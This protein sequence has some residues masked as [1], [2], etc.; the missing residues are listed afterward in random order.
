MTHFKTLLVALVLGAAATAQ[1]QL[2]NIDASHGF[3][4]DGGGSDP[5]PL[6][7]QHI[8]PIGAPVTLALGAGTYRVRNAAGQAGALFDAWS[9]NLGTSSWAWAFVTYDAGSQNTLFYAQAGSGSSRAQVAA[10]PQVQA[11]ETTFTLAQATTVGFTLRDY[12]VPDNG[13]GISLRVSAVP[14]P[15]MALLWLLGAAPL[16]RIA[17]RRGQRA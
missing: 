3:T 6:P 11:F 16:W 5:A 15:A 13:G 14:E 1:A 7:G 8:N 17:R 12:Y 9:Y 4:F 10:L 2:L